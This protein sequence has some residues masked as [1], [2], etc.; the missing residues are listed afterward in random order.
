MGLLDRLR[1]RR[2]DADEAAAT[3]ESD[4]GVPPPVDVAARSAQLVE[5]DD[6]LRALARGLA[7]DTARMRVPGYAQRVED[8]RA[9]A[10]EAARLERDGFD[11]ADLT[12]LANQ[13]VPL[14]RPG[15][16]LPSEYEAVAEPYARV[17]AATDALRAVLASE[18]QPSDG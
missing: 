6:S 12:D 15:A 10:A 4:S 11:R 18:G 8:Y 2:G 17:L 7:A 3:D 9:V 14:A 13:V 1:G 5:L 16:A